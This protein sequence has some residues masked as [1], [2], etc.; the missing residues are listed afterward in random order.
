LEGVALAEVAARTGASILDVW[1]DEWVRLMRINKPPYPN[2]DA[3]QAP[4]EADVISGLTRMAKRTSDLATIHDKEMA[5]QRE[6]NKAKKLQAARLDLRAAN[7]LKR[8]A[9]RFAKEVNRAVG[10]ARQQERKLRR[11]VT[12]VMRDIGACRKKLGCYL[13][14]YMAG[15][16]TPSQYALFRRWLFDSSFIVL[17]RKMNMELNHL[18]KMVRYVVRLLEEHYA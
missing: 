8:E 17:A 18:T 16:V 14:G 6:R 9:A 13:P 11:R 4:A 3:A 12:V 1:R 2:K 10:G 7:S 5:R 15:F